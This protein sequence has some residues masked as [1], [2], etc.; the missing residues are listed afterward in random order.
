MGGAWAEA[1]EHSESNAK[2]SAK[3]ARP[4]TFMV[5]LTSDTD[6]FHFS[7]S[8]TTIKINATALLAFGLYMV[9]R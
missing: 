7:K 1:S 9:W 8:L 2:P 3:R 5:D 6:A 4:A